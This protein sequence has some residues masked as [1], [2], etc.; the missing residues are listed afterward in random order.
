MKNLPEK[1][2]LQIDADGET[3]EDFDE[4][5]GVT[6]CEERIND[7]DIEYIVKPQNDK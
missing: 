2:Y 7:N 1:I 4:L 5:D 3:P 6:W